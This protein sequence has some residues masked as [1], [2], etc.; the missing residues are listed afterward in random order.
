MDEKIRQAVRSRAQ[1]RCEYCLL[2]QHD[3]PLVRFHVEHV[4]PRKHG[5]TDSTA[6]L[7]LACLSCNLHKGS[8]LAGIDPRTGRLT[9]LFHPRE[10]HW[11]DHFVMKPRTCEVHGR[12]AVGRATVEV[13]LLNKP[14]RLELRR[15]L[16][17]M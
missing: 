5:G 8:N 2:H 11:P 14:S 10:D 9:R 1:D 6:N 3:S 12:T 17:E 4:V 13:L 7:A 15:L 16:A